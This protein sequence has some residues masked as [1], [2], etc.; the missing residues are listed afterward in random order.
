MAY[1]T[2]IIIIIMVSVLKMS[3]SLCVVSHWQDS[4]FYY[5]LFVLSSMFSQKSCII[6]FP[7]SSIQWV[8]QG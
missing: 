6:N 7:I 4:F 8:E 1:E 3:L 2:C 5:T